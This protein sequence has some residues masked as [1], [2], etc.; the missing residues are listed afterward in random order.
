MMKKSKQQVN[1]NIFSVKE[2]FLLAQSDLKFTKKCAFIS[3]STGNN[4]KGMQEYPEN[5]CMEKSPAAPYW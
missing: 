5:Y 4:M 1:E 3:P 2:F